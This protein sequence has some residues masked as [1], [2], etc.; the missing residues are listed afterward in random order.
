MDEQVGGKSTVAVVV[1]VIVV[2]VHCGV[3]ERTSHN[4]DVC[5]KYVKLII[6][7]CD[8]VGRRHTHCRSVAWTLQTM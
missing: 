1:V 6:S 3:A 8:F 2:I 4:R 7:T 5:R